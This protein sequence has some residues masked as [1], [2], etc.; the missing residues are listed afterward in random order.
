MLEYLRARL[1]SVTRPAASTSSRSCR[2]R[3][4]AARVARNHSPTVAGNAG[5]VGKKL[6][7][8]LTSERGGPGA[9]S[10]REE[11]RGGSSRRKRP[12]S[13]SCINAVAVNVFECEA[14]RKICAG[15]SAT[16]PL[17]SA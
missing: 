5:A 13:A 2:R 8:T 4:K 3:E 6:A 17:R 10:A 16:G 12:R 14:T 9:R 11:G 7:Y 1:G 15:V